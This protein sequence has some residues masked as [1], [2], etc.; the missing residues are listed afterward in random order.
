MKHEEQYSEI[1][2]LLAAEALEGVD[3]IESLC[4][5]TRW[6]F[7]G[8]LQRRVLHFTHCPDPWAYA[9]TFE[10]AAYVALQYDV[11]RRLEEVQ[12]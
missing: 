11:R 6:V 5:G 2:N 7:D 3:T 9:T 1:V 4:S 8:R 10:Q 12:S